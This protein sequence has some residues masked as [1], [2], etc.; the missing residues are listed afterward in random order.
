MGEWV[1]RLLIAQNPAVKNRH[2]LVSKGDA[3]SDPH[4]FIIQILEIKLP[5]PSQ[6]YHFVTFL[7]FLTSF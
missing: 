5:N 2:A 6:P 4:N 3:D 7:V 1:L